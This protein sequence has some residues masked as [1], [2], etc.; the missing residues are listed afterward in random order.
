V[1]IAAA[2]SRSASVRPRSRSAIGAPIALAKS[3]SPP[4]TEPP[5][6]SATGLSRSGTATALKPAV[7]GSMIAWVSACGVS[8]VPPSVWHILWCR[9]MPT[10]PSTA[11]QS[12]AP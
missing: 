11:P 3:Q 12:Q 2:L 4:P 10:V 1:A 6:V 7:C 9:A 8:N 5:N